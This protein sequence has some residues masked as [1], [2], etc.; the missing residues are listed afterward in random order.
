MHFVLT[1]MLMLSTVFFLTLISIYMLILNDLQKQQVLK[2]ENIHADTQRYYKTIDYENTLQV[3]NDKN[4]KLNE[5][6][7]VVDDSGHCLF[8]S[9][10]GL[11]SKEDIN[12]VILSTDDSLQGY[13]YL[14]NQKLKFSKKIIE[15]KV[16]IDNQNDITESIYQYAFLDVSNFTKDLRSLL[17]I[18]ISVG[19]L[20]LSILLCISVFLAKKAIEPIERSYQQQKQFIQDISHELKTPLASIKAN[21]AVVLSN[22]NSL[23]ASQKKWLDHIGF[24][25]QRMNRLIHELLELTK[26]EQRNRKIELTKINLSEM[27]RH[28]L[29]GFETLFFEKGISLNVDVIDD[30]YIKGNLDM[31]NQVLSILLDNAVKYTNNNGLV[32]ITIKNTKRQISLIIQ[33][34]GKGIE[35]EDIDKIFDRFYRGD[36]ARKHDGGYGLGLAIASTLM[37]QMNGKIEVTS[38][39]QDKTTFTIS[40]PN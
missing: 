37:K 19:I 35:P 38:I 26:I 10:F 1:N 22:D 16:S 24:E 12:K 4:Q 28:T 29:I 15:T 30:I 25:S 36:K 14:N 21:L 17:T 40:W 32:N 31:V 3:I 13:I 6:G 39:P 5:F 20:S 8:E 18:F 33:N 11:I 27:L 23:V 34:T 7:I 9:S 2:L